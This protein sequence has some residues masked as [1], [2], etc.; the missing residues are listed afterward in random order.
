MK[1]NYASASVISDI[2]HAR[3]RFQNSKNKERMGTH[4]MDIR[5][6]ALKLLDSVLSLDME[7][8]PT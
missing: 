1:E 4:Y 7:K 2:V 5:P 8:T 3:G 6:M